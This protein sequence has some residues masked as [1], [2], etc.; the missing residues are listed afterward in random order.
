MKCGVTRVWIDPSRIK[1]VQEAIT[2][3]DVRK[4]IS[5]GV[6]KKLPKQGISSYRKNKIRL[7]KKKGRRRGQG[8][9]KGYPAALK[10]TK[11][12]KRIR[13]IRRILKELKNK[14]RITNKTY[15]QM[16]RTAKS[17][18]FRSKA[19][20]ISHLEKNELLKEEKRE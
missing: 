3:H 7:Q 13:V 15:W 2:G 18:F 17:G 16:Y 6:I 20:L 5:E 9:R 4:F 11:W 10:K 8:T 1:D 14:E 12:A 19:H